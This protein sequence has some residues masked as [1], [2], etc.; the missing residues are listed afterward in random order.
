MKLKFES[1]LEYQLEAIRSVTDLFEGLPASRNAFTI[2]FSCQ[3]GSMGLTQTDLGMAN[4]PPYSS[5]LTFA[6]FHRVRMTG[7]QR[8]LF[9]VQE[10][11]R[12]MVVGN[13][14]EFLN[15]SL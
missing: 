8:K 5:A 12:E 15:F 9:E 11:R 1:K 10:A 3:I 13:V 6:S 4:Q 2:S 7:K 14:R